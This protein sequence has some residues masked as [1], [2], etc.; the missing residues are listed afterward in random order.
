LVS[1]ISSSKSASKFAQLNNEPNHLYINAGISKETKNQQK[2][3]NLNPKIK[4]T[5]RTYIY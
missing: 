2:S 4:A 1:L 3:E 5:T